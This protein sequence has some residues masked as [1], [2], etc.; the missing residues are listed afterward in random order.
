MCVIALHPQT[1]LLS[2]LESINSTGVIY[3]ILLGALSRLV[4]DYENMLP[5]L[6]TCDRIK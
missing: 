3:I 2:E 6:L 1:I 5:L 4:F